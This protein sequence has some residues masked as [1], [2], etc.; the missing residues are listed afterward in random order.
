MTKPLQLLILEDNT[1][2]MELMLAQLRSAGFELDWTRTDNEADYLAALESQPDLIL[3]DYSLPSFSGIKALE[4]RNQRGLDI[5]FILVSGTVGEDTAVTAMKQ[6]A[7]DYLLKDRLTRLGEAVRHALEQKQLRDEKRISVE[8]LQK[9]FEQVTRA[10][11]TLHALSLVAQAATRAHTPQDI[12]RAVSDEIKRL[13]F[14]LVVIDFNAE[15]QDMGI[16]YLSYEDRFVRIAEKITGLSARNYRLPL[17]AGSHY[18]QI[19]SDRKTVLHDDIKTIIEETLPPLL[20]PFSGRLMKLVGVKQGIYAALVVDGKPQGIFIISGSNLKQEDIAAVDILAA[21]VSIALENAQLYQSLQQELSERIT[22]ENRLRVAEAN[23]RSILEN[24]PVGFFQTTPEGGFLAVNPT[25]ALIC[26]YASP[27]EMMESVTDMGGQIYADPAEWVEFR[28]RMNENGEVREFVNRDRRKDGQIIWVSTNARMV[29]DA[30]GKLLYYEG[31]LT[32][33]TE[34]KQAEQSLKRRADEFAALFETARELTIA[35]ELDQLLQ[36]VLKQAITLVNAHA[37]SIGLFDAA[38]RSVELIAAVNL[39]TPPHS[40]IALGEGLNGRVAESLQPMIVNDYSTW[41]HRISLTQNEAG[42]VAAVPMLHQGELI[43]ILSV[44]E[45]PESERQYSQADLDLLTLFAAPAAGAV[46]SARLY[47]QAQQEI[48]TRKYAEEKLEHQLQRLSALREI[49]HIITSTF[50]MRLSLNALVSRTVSLLDVDAVTILLLNPVTNTLEHGASLGF[51][52]NAVKTASVRLGD[53]YA[54]KAAIEQ[55]IVQIPNLT[56]EPDNLLLKSLLK[57]EKFVSY[58]GAPLIVKGK[59]IGVMELFHRSVVERDGEWFDFFNTMA[60]QAALA[61]DNAGLFEDLQRANMNLEARVRERTI[62]LTRA[63]RAKDEFLASMSHELRTPLS[64]I[65]S[66]SESLEAGTYGEL[67]ARQLEILHIV[68]ESGKHLL[69]LI[70]DILDLAK[71]EAGKLE[72]SAGPMAVELFCQASLRMIKQIAFQKNVDVSMSNTSNIEV[73]H[74]DERR[75]KQMLVNLL[76]NAVKFTPEGGQVGLEV[77]KEGDHAIRFCVWDTGIGIPADQLGKL[78]QPFMQLDSSLSRQYTGTGLGLALVR[79]LAELHGGSV[80]V[81]S[82][83][84]RGSRFYF[85]VPI[86]VLGGRK[87]EGEQRESSAWVKSAEA[88]VSSQGEKRRI[89]LVEDNAINM[90][91]TYDFLNDR[92]YEVITA[93]NG[94]E[95]LEKALEKN[96][97]L[98]LMDI[99]MP[100]MDGLETIRRLRTAPEFG[101]VPIIALTALAM[102]GDRE[103]CLEA[104]ANEYISKPVSL[105]KLFENIERLL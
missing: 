1:S 87:I 78:F 5:P 30:E 29:K 57:G 49:D 73:I 26:G 20:R 12:Y 52:T 35:Q 13:G 77:T 19:L 92:G 41:E 71:I 90:M 6:G 33:V 34:R 101:S 86:Q 38:Q 7:A 31:F 59:V 75:L 98:I 83:V 55:R 81:E 9:S 99:Q 97:D 46:K 27:K 40:R 61:I 16:A 95:A 25:M 85:I 8:A 2:D 44:E 72:L 66:L 15:K 64:G 100:G 22:A 94:F 42:A 93:V 45:L 89:L 70:N 21:Q 39:E 18:N 104:G 23:Y 62:E 28:R 36:T 3:A 67:T 105:K 60:G 58:Y 37:G 76:S 17:T 10:Q 68:A 32:D 24:A 4:L 50:D 82:K 48:A 102:P 80:G 65:M 79:D 63:N 88:H 11:S 56:N 53:S 54:G 43:G 91:V 14:D 103:R 84:G 74:A 96:P 69:E 47:Q 51:W